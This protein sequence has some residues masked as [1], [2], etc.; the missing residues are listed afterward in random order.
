MKEVTFKD[1]QKNLTPR[2]MWVW[3]DS[4]DDKKK[5]KVIYVLRSESILY[6]V[7]AV[8]EEYVGYCTYKHCAEIEEPKTRRMTN[9]EL[10][11]W[12]REKPT[13]EYTTPSQHFIYSAMAYGK[14]FADKE[15]DD[16][17]LIRENGGEWHEPLVELAE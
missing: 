16:D 10:A 7:M 9:Q 5:A 14:E 4:F 2:M 15:V 8:H 13:R 17:F 6:P 1:W 12:L 3:N 11:W